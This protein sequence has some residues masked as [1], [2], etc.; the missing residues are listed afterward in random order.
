[1]TA[2][3][4]ILKAGADTSVQDAGRTAFRHL[5]TP[6]SG[7]VDRLSF[8]LANALVGNAWDA[9]ALECAGV[10]PNLQFIKEAAFALAGA[11]MSATVNEATIEAF[12]VHHAKPGDILKLGAAKTGLRAYIAIAGGVSGRNELGGVATYAPAGLGGIDGRA[13]QEGD[14]IRCAD[15]PVGSPVN[16][17]PSDRPIIAND[18]VLRIV[19]G[20]EFHLIDAAA[21]KKFLSEA[22]TVSR[23]GNRMGVELNGAPIRPPDHFTMLSS[24]VY[25][26]TIQCPPSGDPFLLLADAQTVGGYAR[27]G[28]VIDADLH[29]AGQLRPG[30]RIWFSAVSAENARATTA[31]KAAYY[32]D[33]LP[34]FRFG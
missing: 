6:Q 30:A 3:A 32:R 5:G 1:V 22:L 13:L 4:T 7:A 33:Y 12:C 29:L 17:A 16:I 25:P 28:Q 2:V 21:Q 23:R 15:G 10:G 8:A 26:G 31:H 34:K 24:P 9:P 14:T 27:I 19:R 11:D 20:P 18:T